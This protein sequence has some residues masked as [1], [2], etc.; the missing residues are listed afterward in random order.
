MSAE[1]A[2]MA[3]SLG[4]RGRPARCKSSSAQRKQL[5]SRQLYRR[6]LSNQ[7]QATRRA[8]PSRSVLKQTSCRNELCRKS[9]AVVSS[10]LVSSPLSD[11]QHTR[12]PCACVMPSI[13]GAGGRW[14]AKGLHHV[15]SPASI[16]CHSPRSAHL[17]EQ[18]RSTQTKP[19]PTRRIQPKRAPSLA[20]SP[21]QALPSPAPAPAHAMPARETTRPR[22]R[23][24]MEARKKP[25]RSPHASPTACLS[26]LASGNLGPL[27]FL[28]PACRVF[29]R[30]RCHLSRVRMGM[31][32]HAPS[33]RVR[34]RQPRPAVD[35]A[36]PH[37]H[38][39]MSLFSDPG[40]YTIPTH[41]P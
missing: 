16:R 41:D 11:S 19:A 13:I 40:A 3:A 23:R 9:S 15:N 5:G 6:E 14:A 36:I 21:L 20:P 26:R 31:E 30:R 8:S 37:N 4:R 17:L 18:T 29:C 25:A 24:C 2:E 35:L 33:I 10:R 1:G 27:S 22:A 38:L 39:S 28:Q 34:S 32:S 12:P 7:R